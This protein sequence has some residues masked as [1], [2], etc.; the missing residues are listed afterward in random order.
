ME[1]MLHYAWQ[2][3]MFPLHR[4]T[5]TLGHRVE[6]IHPGHHNSDSGPDFLGAHLLIDGIEWIGN[7][8]IHLNSSD[9]YRHH[10]DSD[11]AYDNVVLHVVQT[12]D[13]PVSNSQGREIMQMKLDIPEY[14]KNNYE[15]LLKSDR[16]PRCKNYINNIPSLTITSW[17]ATL[18]VERLEERTTQIME[19][20]KQC[21]LNW[22]H[23]AFVTIARNFGFGKNGDAFERW[24]FSIPMNAISKHR[25]D[26]FQIEA[27]FFGQAGLLN[28]DYYRNDTELSDY[29]YKLQAEYRYLSKKFSL[30]SIDPKCWRYMR[31]H[32]Q[33][34]PHIRIAQLAMIYHREHVN[35]SR[36][37]GAESIEQMRDLL[38]TE[39]SDYWNNHFSF[40]TM[41]SPI[42]PKRISVN[43]CNLII[44]NSFIPLT[45][46]YGRHKMDESLCDKTIELMEK[47]QPETNSIINK[48]NEAGIKCRSAAESQALLQLT[49]R[50][51]EPKDC[52]R[53]RLGSEYIRHTPDYLREEKT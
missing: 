27:I 36:I 19:R 49:T 43:S 29:F 42:Q 33:N 15:E 48:W 45:F 31:M 37:I 13:C 40:S 44:I 10:H 53:C 32:P 47:M 1:Y 18:F 20:R 4:L 41:E 17:L 28:D 3:R 9:W 23:T 46:A 35:L 11:E 25:N 51:C 8:E 22:E 38:K 52:L 21:D 6:V 12:A 5:T 26:L 50:Y 24:A 39:T 34:F 16:H 2:H 14:V 30:K 7:V